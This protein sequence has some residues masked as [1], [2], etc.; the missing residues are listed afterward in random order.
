VAAFEETGTVLLVEDEEA[1]AELVAR[2]F[3]RFGGF[4]L[5]FAATVSEARHV[6][7]SKDAP[8]DLVVADLKLPDGTGTELLEPGGVPLI[9]MTSHGGEVAAVEAMK[10]GAL[11]YVVKSES[12]LSDMP[13]I[14]SR[15]LREVR[16]R[17]E[18]DRVD[19]ERRR[20]D[21]RLRL[22]LQNAP[23]SALGQGCDLRIAWAHNPRLAF[24]TDSVLGKT[25]EELLPADSAA[26]LM[27]LKRGVL[28]SG[29]PTREEVRLA[30][31]G[32]IAVHDVSIFPQQDGVGRVI[33]L[34]SVS[35]D[36]TERRRLEEALAERERLASLGT[37]AAMLAHE[38][39]NP[40]N[41][42][43]LHAQMLERRSKKQGLEETLASGLGSIMVEINRLNELVR[44]F[45]ALSRRQTLDDLR[46]TD[47]AALLGSVLDSTAA[48]AAAQNVRIERDF[49]VELTLSASA[50][51]L[52]QVFVNLCKNAVEAMPEGGTLTVRATRQGDGVV[53]EVSDTG[54]GIPPGVDPFEPFKTTKPEGTGL[55]LA[56]VQQLV[57]THGG[58]VTYASAPGEGTAFTVALPGAPSRRTGVPPSS[59]R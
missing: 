16:L 57:L 43:Y 33:G 44:G 46:P 14:A 42:M 47:L 7:S 23:I 41:A 50:D 4:R 17:A 26:R 9:V 35:I 22:A 20:S 49:A 21:E 29:E 15:V 10:A 3:E 38:V 39:A 59:D 31:G 24:G 56:V 53:V 48:L 40:L 13:R 11:D 1:H 28:E 51:K 54:V 6:L 2:A 18:H 58:R 45:R 30:V 25:D 52:V 55:G 27:T 5:A 32:D 36:I 37:A 19:E 12:T 34:L 8:L